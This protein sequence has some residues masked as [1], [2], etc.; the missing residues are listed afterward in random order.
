MSVDLI[1]KANFSEVV[2]VNNGFISGWASVPVIDRSYDLILGESANLEQHKQN[3]VVLWCHQKNIAIGRAKT[4]QGAY[5][6]IQKTYE[7]N[8]YTGLWHSTEFNPHDEFAQKIYKSYE[9]GFLRGW[10]VGF[11]PS[12]APQKLAGERTKAFGGD[13]KTSVRYFS[14]INL[15]EYSAVPIPDNQLALSDDR[16]KSLGVPDEYMEIIKSLTPRQTTFSARYHSPALLKPSIRETVDEPVE[17]C[18]LFAG[19]LP[20]TK[21]GEV[22]KM[23]SDTTATATVPHGV[24]VSGAAVVVQKAPSEGVVE[25]AK[26]ETKQQL[27][28]GAITKSNEPTPDAVQKLWSTLYCLQDCVMRAGS[29]ESSDDAD[30]RSLGKKHKSILCDAAEVISAD[31]TS[32]FPEHAGKVSGLLSWFRDMK[33]SEP[34]E[35][36]LSAMLPQ[37]Q[38]IIRDEYAAIGSNMIEVQKEQNAELIGDAVEAIVIRVNQAVGV[39]KSV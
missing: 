26:E 1:Q 2:E 22:Q 34:V 29:Q 35:K 33:P 19:E 38:S 7:P 28:E 30:V 16:F 23:T 36:S 24:D 31:I 37:L 25:S 5:G 17:S 21:S 15:F 8:G 6:L 27:A 10:S 11:V 32:Q 20:R 12:K 4:Q 9:T 39:M 14:A 13:G 3:P 18:E